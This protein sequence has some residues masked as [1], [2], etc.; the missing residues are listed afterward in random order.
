MLTL[1]TRN[2]WRKLRGMSSFTTVLGR[3]SKTKTKRLTVG[4]KISEK[5]NLTC[6]CYFD[7]DVVV[8]LG[9]KKEI[10]LLAA[11]FP[12]RCP[13]CC[14]LWFSREHN[15]RVHSTI[16]LNEM[17]GYSRL[18]DR[19]DRLRLYGNISLCDRLRSAIVCDHMETSLITDLFKAEAMQCAAVNKT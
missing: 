3:I 17:Y 15:A 7:A 12:P 13:P 8:A 18:C 1:L 5:F 4:K 11:K 16:P 10:N 14:L 9:L 2:L 6:L 19:C